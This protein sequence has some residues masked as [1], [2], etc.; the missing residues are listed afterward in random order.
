MNR[1][2]RMNLKKSENHA[3]RPAPIL[4]GAKAKARPFDHPLR[5]RTGVCGASAP[6]PRRSCKEEPISFL[7]IPDTYKGKDA[8]RRRSWDLTPMVMSVMGGIGMGFIGL[9][10]TGQL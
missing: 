1:E 8:K 6:P 9:V 3:I 5:D 10:F 2:P 4:I 7:N